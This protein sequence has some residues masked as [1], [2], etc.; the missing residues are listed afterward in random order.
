MKIT[1]SEKILALIRKH[2]RV[3][4]EEIINYI[5]LTDRAV[6][7]SLNKLVES[8]QLVKHGTPPKVHYS[9]GVGTTLDNVVTQDL[10]VPEDSQ[11]KKLSETLSPVVNLCLLIHKDGK[12]LVLE[13]DG[14]LELPHTF[15]KYYDSYLTTIEKISKSKL[16]G[17][18]FDPSKSINVAQTVSSKESF[19][20]V[21]ICYLC[22]YIS[23]TSTNKKM[24]WID[25]KA[26][27][28]NEQLTSET[29]H[30][31]GETYKY[32]DTNSTNSNAESIHCSSYI[33]MLN[34]S[35]QL[36]LLRHK[37]GFYDFSSRWDIAKRSH[38]NGHSISQSANLTALNL[39][40]V[41]PTLQLKRAGHKKLGAHEEEYY[42]YFGVSDGPYYINREIFDEVHTFDCEKLLKGHYDKSYDFTSEVYEYVLELKDVWKHL[43]EGGA[44]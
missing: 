24:F 28:S 15:M 44:F 32:F 7:K 43:Q 30:I 20:S 38:I 17:L 13:S 36:L 27:V 42:L 1:T 21:N 11:I 18:K 2:K 14:Q 31:L 29:K 12:F 22:A 3:K 40:G 9:L 41:S 25:R 4:S 8:G 26:L 16:K 5:E 10:V 39:Y 23:G 6:Y 37:T 34:S 33:V 35:G 19:V